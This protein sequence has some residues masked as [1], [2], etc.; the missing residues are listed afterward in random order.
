MDSTQLD[1][2]QWLT[3]IVE[4][5]DDA[6]ISKNLKGI[7]IS[8]NSGA[9]RVFGWTAD[10]AIGKPI[11]IIIPPELRDQEAVILRRLQA[12]ERIDHFETVRQKKSGERIYVS[13]TISPV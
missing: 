13:L 4:S 8:W 1:S 5:S 7:V 6:I 12:G 10:E 3:A 2:T 11:T 9:Q